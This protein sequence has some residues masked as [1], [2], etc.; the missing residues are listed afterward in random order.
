VR[1]VR[2]EG[3]APACADGNADEDEDEQEVEVDEAVQARGKE[4]V[5]ER[6]VARRDV[7]RVERK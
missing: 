1:I 6:S 5:H 3:R 7:T 2:E 4:S